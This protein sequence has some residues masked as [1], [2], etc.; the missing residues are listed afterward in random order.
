MSETKEDH[1]TIIISDISAEDVRSIVE[2]SYQGE[3]RIPVENISNLLDAAQLL[4][5]SGLMEVSIFLSGIVHFGVN[6]V[7]YSEKPN[8]RIS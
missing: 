4:R 1:P 2:F 6:T 3:V 8:L 5:I 7:V